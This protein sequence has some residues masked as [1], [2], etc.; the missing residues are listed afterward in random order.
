MSS[1][2]ISIHIIIVNS[3]SDDL[4]NLRETEMILYWKDSTKVTAQ[5]E[6]DVTAIAKAIVQLSL[7]HQFNSNKMRCSL[8]TNQI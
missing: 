4:P 7:K 5:T 2:A 8:S 3:R 1:K 6:E